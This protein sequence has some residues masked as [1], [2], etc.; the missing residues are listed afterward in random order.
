M[1]LN[2]A[3]ILGQ[4][5]RIGSV[6]PGKA[7]DLAVLRGNLARDISAIRNTTIVFR[8]GYGFDP[9]RLRNAVRGN[10]GAH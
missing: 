3:R 9:V 1:T 5:Q 6:E 7:A 2:G 8:D 10:L 4:Q